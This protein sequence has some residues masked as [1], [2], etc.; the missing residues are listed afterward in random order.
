MKM[1]NFRDCLLS[2]TRKC[3]AANQIGTAHMNSFG[4]VGGI[5]VIWLMTWIVGPI[6]EETLPPIYSVDK[7]DQRG[8][9]A[10]SQAVTSVCAKETRQAK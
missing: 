10:Q 6:R 4:S 7:H 2:P 1:V 8:L 3:D 5:L 9:V